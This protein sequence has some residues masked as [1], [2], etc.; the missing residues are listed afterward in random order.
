MKPEEIA[1]ELEEAGLEPAEVRRM[2]LA[3]LA[4]HKS[5]ASL[6][7]HPHEAAGDASDA[8]SPDVVARAADEPV[9]VRAVEQPRSERDPDEDGK[10]VRLQWLPI[11]G[12][13]LALAAAIVL[14]IVLLPD[15]GITPPH[16]ARNYEPRPE[17]TPD[18]RR[19]EALRKEAFAACAQDLWAPCLQ[20][21]D[22]AKAL[23]PAGDTA[24][25]VREARAVVSSMTKPKDAVPEAP[26]PPVP[27]PRP[28]PPRPPGDGNNEKGP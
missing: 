11:A 10:V 13:V 25:P 23:D 3:V 27:A 22:E 18:E 19:A 9:A 1:A 8:S 17:P 5:S 2:A 7:G 21:L 26:R 4:R 28:R 16:V 12:A 15:Q 6:G 24:Q 14:L 20:A